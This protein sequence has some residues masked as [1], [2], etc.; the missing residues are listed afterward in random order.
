MEEEEE[1]QTTFITASKHAPPSLISLSNFSPSTPRRLSS[2]F[3]NPTRP[4]NSSRRLSWVSLQGRLVNADEA[5]CGEAI[6]GGLSNDDIIAWDLFSPIHR[7]LVVAIIAITTNE[8]RK[9][10]QILSLRRAVDL[11]DQVLLSMQQKLD[12]LCEQVNTMKDR[13]E[14]VDDFSFAKNEGFQLSNDTSSNNIILSN[15]GYCICEQ[16]LVQENAMRDPIEKASGGDEMLKFK[17]AHTML[18]EQEERRMS[19]LS[20]WASSVTS[21]ADIQINAEQ[22]IYN[23]QRECDEKNATI[24]ELSAAVQAADVSG[25]KRIAELEDVIR[26]KNMIITKL[27]KDMMVLEQKVVHLV[28]LRRPSSSN[29]STQQLPV[30][31]ENFLF[32]MDST[33]NSSSSDSD[34]DFKN[35]PQVSVPHEDLNVPSNNKNPAAASQ[36][37]LQATISFPRTAERP[38][39]QWPISPLKENTMNQINNSKVTLRPK[40]LI[41][42]LGDQRKG[43]RRS[44]YGLKQTTPVKRWS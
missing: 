11:R 27:K 18:V 19:D 34:S 24:R 38:P 30:M 44:Q 7:V 23:L 22:D 6:K 1:Q 21:A 10:K 4:I 5:S 28:R 40:Q 17:M 14:N 20:D 35:Q 31:T 25:S 16:H 41:S 15:C 33:T 39:K 37:A 29:V 13:P 8:L 3:N 42:T 36:R 2:Q 32:D 26:R 9:N 12:D 43:R